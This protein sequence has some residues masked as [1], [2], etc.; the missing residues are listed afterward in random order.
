M[1]AEIR[2]VSKGMKQTNF[3]IDEMNMAFK[4]NGVRYR[5]LIRH[6][7]CTRLILINEDEGDF[8]ESECANS[9]GLDLVM[10]FIRA[11]LAD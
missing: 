3:I 1:E 7:D 10:R 2:S 5:L 11:K 6:D 4:H 9:I 8:V